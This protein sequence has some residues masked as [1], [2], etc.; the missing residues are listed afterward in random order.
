MNLFHI[1]PSIL[2]LV[3]AL[4]SI[5]GCRGLIIISQTG[6]E[7]ESVQESHFKLL[8]YGVEYSGRLQASLDNPT[9]CHNAQVNVPKDS[10]PVALLARSG[11]CSILQKAKMASSMDPHNLVKY[12]IIYSA[13]D[14]A[15][16][17]DDSD[18]A[19]H[20]IDVDLVNDFQALM[21]TSGTVPLNKMTGMTI[22]KT[23][24]IQDYDD[25][26][27]TVL[28]V[29]HQ[30]GVAL[31]GALDKQTR[32]SYE[33]GG[34]VVLLD[35]RGWIPGYDY[36]G[37]TIADL[38]LITVLGFLCCVSMSC[39]FSSNVR[40]AGVVIVEAGDAERRLPGRYRHGLRLLNR[41]EVERLPEVEFGLDRV[42][43]GDGMGKG[44]ETN[45]RVGTSGDVSDRDALPSQEEV[46][47]IQGEIQIF[48]AAPVL[49]S[50]GEDGDNEEDGD[51]EA[52]G[53]NNHFE[54]IACTICLEDYE[55]GDKLRVLPCHH[56]FHSPCIVPWL[57]DRAPTCPLCKALFEVT[58]EGDDEISDD[59]DDSVDAAAS[60][61]ASTLDDLSTS[62][63]FRTWF[64]SIFSREPSEDVESSN[65]NEVSNSNDDTR[66]NP[67]ALERGGASSSRFWSTRNDPLAPER[68][69]TSPSRFWS[70]ILAFGRGDAPVRTNA[71][72]DLNLISGQNSLSE[73]LLAT[74]N[75][76]EDSGSHRSESEEVESEDNTNNV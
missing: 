30:S 20:Y 32:K 36:D 59:D 61:A 2:S 4:I 16:S 76:S 12:L 1:I 25:I 40:S 37:A 44:G 11:E 33:D 34:L 38:I 58:R 31:Q 64:F 55:D 52:G 62:P 15:A 75:D 5:P 27:I 41:N 70:R 14:G 42:L 51:H 56:A 54:D 63:D 68:D 57:T 24:V 9:L 46:N 8:V 7:F 19:S 73:P 28:Y 39:L 13:G 26:N 29:S 21:Q 45:E 3:V 53:Y 23:E 18:D 35:Q 66:N 10:V 43:D 22:R 69:G 67:P 49:S 17:D 50:R 74:F 72:A 48:P 71:D 47:S 60:H 6:E 65:N